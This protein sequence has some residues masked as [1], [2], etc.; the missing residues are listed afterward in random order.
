MNKKTLDIIN[1][2]MKYLGIKYAYIKWKG[3]P[4]YPYFIG[5]Y[6]ESPPM[7]ESGLHESTFILTGHAR[8]SAMPLEDAREKIKEYFDPVNGFLATMEDGSTVAIFYSDSFS[9]PTVD[10]DLEKIQINLD[11]KEWRVLK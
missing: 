1:K 4:E 10:A 6:Q 8:G 7:N 3:T 2:S 11:V 5:E 9:V